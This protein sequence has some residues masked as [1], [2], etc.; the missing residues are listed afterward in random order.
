[1]VTVDLHLE[2][3][4]AGAPGSITVVNSD[5]VIAKQVNTATLSFDTGATADKLVVLI[6]SERSMSAGTAV[7]TYN[8]LP[9]NKISNGIGRLA[10]V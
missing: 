8:G 6:S 2:V 5:F 7:V 1:M 9:L 3:I 10:G 4:G